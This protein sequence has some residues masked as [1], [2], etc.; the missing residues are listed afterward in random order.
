MLE[1]LIYLSVA[2]VMGIVFYLYIK[3]MKAQ[4]QITGSKIEQAKE[5]GI[6]EPVSLHPH[7]DL[8]TCI[9]SGACLEACPEEDVLGIQGGRAT[10]INA[11]HCVGHGACFHACPMEA[12]TLRIGTE[13]RGVDLPHVN[14]SFETN[15]EGIFIAGELGGMG[16]IKNSVEQGKQAMD[17]IAKS[18]TKG[19]SNE[20]DVIIIGAGP[21]GISASLQAKNHGLNALTLDQDSIGGTVFSFP[22]AKVVMT[23]PM[24]LPLYGKLKLFHTSKTELLTL[25]TN[26]INK[27][28]IKIVENQKVESIT[29]IPQGFE[30]TTLQEKKYTA[31]KVLLSIGRR[32]TP[33]KL[34]VK[35]EQ[36]EKVAYRILEPELISGK[37]ILVVGGGDSA[38]ENALLLADQNTVH[39]SY[40]G[41]KFGRLKPLN[42]EN[43]RTAS[44]TNKLT[45]LMESNV[46]EITDKTVSLTQKDS[47]NLTIE[48]DF[49]YIFAGGELPTSFLQKAGIEIHKRFG[50][51]VREHG[52]G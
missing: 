19:H 48:N 25:W 39:L 20:Y 42:A 10:L 12:I 38:I 3:K 49:V 32:G 17:S 13:K 16:L 26:V 30:I 1:L 50:Y 15:V 34:G 41:E 11:S 27:N 36:L 35:G 44:E 37:K 28:Q 6:F 23:A 14:Q 40:R 18:I 22:R 47:E 4:D 21:A 43:I 33:R 24:D 5:S 46:I 45:L 8:N 51:T 9:K 31:Q 2:A 7:I 52:K 29:L